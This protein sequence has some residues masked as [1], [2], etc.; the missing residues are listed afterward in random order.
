M[1]GAYEAVGRLGQACGHRVALVALAPKDVPTAGA[2][3]R[4]LRALGHDHDAELVLRAFSDDK[5]RAAI[6]KAATI[7]PLAA[8]V[9]GDLVVR[10]H[11]DGGADLDVSIVSPEGTRLSWMGGRPDLAVADVT[12]AEREELAIKSLKRGN[13]LV[14]I[15][16]GAPS[17][18]AVRG[19]LDIAVLGIRRSLPFELVGDRLVVGRISVAL[20]SH[21]EE[22][23]NGERW[24]QIAPET[25]APMR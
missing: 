2:A 5:T 17:S 7:A 19:T 9:D 21:L 25:L 1:I 23:D 15:G 22:V 3:V 20:E 16:R 11:W 8:R 4:C 12:S 18:G 13:Y 6:E 10:A 24:R 14:E